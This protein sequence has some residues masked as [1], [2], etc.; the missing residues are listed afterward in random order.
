MKRLLRF[1]RF[2]RRF[3][4]EEK[5]SST[6]EFAMMFPLIVIIMISSFELGILMVRQVLLDRAVDLAVREVRL[7]HI[8]PVTHDKLKNAIC[9]HA[10][11]LPNCLEDMRIEM[12]RLDLL[13]WSDPPTTTECVDREDRGRPLS[14][15]QQG[16]ANQLM[17]VRVCSIFDPTFP[18]L[19]L[20]RA[21]ATQSD[22]TYGLVAVSSFVMEPL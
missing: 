2:F 1:P 15:F 18:H 14:S 6:V 4:K 13:A 19:S 11:A 22:D 12:R 7:S 5:G 3:A 17:L 20:S 16:A 8:T 9:E 21:L 10:V